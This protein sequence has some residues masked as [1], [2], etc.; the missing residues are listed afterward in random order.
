MFPNPSARIKD[1]VGTN[2]AVSLQG[3]HYI[4]ILTA[5]V[6]VV[7]ELRR[8]LLTLCTVAFTNS[9]DPLSSYVVRG[10]TSIVMLQY[11]LARGKLLFTV[12]A[13]LFSFYSF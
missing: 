3:R 10:I 9:S 11:W 6:N 12:F 2:V 13:R 4:S 8:Q 1:R 7:R 5:H